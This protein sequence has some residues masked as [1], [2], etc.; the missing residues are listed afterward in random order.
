MLELWLCLVCWSFFLLFL[1]FFR[2]YIPTQFALPR[3]A[4]NPRAATVV[5]REA[6]DPQII[7]IYLYIVYCI[8]V[9]NRRPH[10]A[11]LQMPAT[12]WL[13]CKQHKYKWMD[14]YV[15][16]TEYMDFQ[17]A[18]VPLSSSYGSAVLLCL[19]EKKPFLTKT[20]C[21]VKHRKYFT[22]CCIYWML[23]VY[24]WPYIS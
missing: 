24:P 19:C 13:V 3:A 6:H 1:F 16:V 14:R 15:H 21:V 5:A 17:Y 2:V 11:H 8:Y 9:Y 7:S 20:T 4:P 10:P 18:L 12:G 22:V 23:T